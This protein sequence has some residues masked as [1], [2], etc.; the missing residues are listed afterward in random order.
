MPARQEESESVTFVFQ[1]TYSH[2]Y[3]TSF[4]QKT[5]CD[6]IALQGSSSKRGR[7]RKTRMLT[8]KTSMVRGEIPSA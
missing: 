3:L 1:L 2:V 7:N 6:P 4:P 5:F 8:W